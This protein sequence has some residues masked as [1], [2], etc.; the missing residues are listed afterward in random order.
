[1]KINPTFTISSFVTLASIHSTYYVNAF[2]S[3]MPKT[4]ATTQ[5]QLQRQEAS[6][7]R[8]AATSSSSFESQQAPA[9]FSSSSSSKEEEV[10]VV[11]DYNSINK[12]KFRELQAECKKRSIHA[13]GSTAVLRNRLLDSC[14]ILMVGKEE[15]AKATVEVSLARLGC[16]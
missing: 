13:V 14:G 9:S 16:C 1:M 7:I 12:L 3:C 10:E 11:L 2:T 6:I 5:R 15:Q 8:V 4:I